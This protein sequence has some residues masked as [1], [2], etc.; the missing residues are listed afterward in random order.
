MT[1]VPLPRAPSVGSSLN[2]AGSY[3]GPI[4]AIGGT[5][6]QSQLLTP[7][8][9]SGFS[10]SG[11]VLTGQTVPVDP[12]VTNTAPLLGERERKKL[13]KEAERHQRKY[14]KDLRKA[15]NS[16]TKAEKLHMQGRDDK[17]VKQENKAG[18]LIIQA[19]HE[20]KWASGLQQELAHPGAS[21]AP[22]SM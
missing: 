15:E 9:A 13:S 7:T 4:T 2:P 12:Y 18:K 17:A 11:P 3:V 16:R 19:E 21:A 10:S 14:E 8:T 1:A 22:A 5:G 20:K 6:L